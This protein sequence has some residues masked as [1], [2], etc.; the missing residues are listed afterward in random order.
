M[1]TPRLARCA[2][3][4]LLVAVVLAVLGA[5]GC[6][7]LGN[8]NIGSGG[9]KPTLTYY[10]EDRID[11]QYPAPDFPNPFISPHSKQSALPQTFVTLGLYVPRHSLQ[12][13]EIVSITL[14]GPDGALIASAAGRNDLMDYWNLIDYDSY[15]TR[16]QNEM[17]RRYYVPDGALSGRLLGRDYVVVIP[18]KAAV[19][20]GARVQAVLRLDDTVVTIVARLN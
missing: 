11:E 19:P 8:G 14:V 6:S 16:K 18:C 9:E 3:A 7:T 20:A 15:A 12:R 13:L 17:I 1:P 5:M 10:S 4:P 2:A